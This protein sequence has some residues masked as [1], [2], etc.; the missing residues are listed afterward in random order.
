MKTKKTNEQKTFK[1]LVEMNESQKKEVSGGFLNPII[2]C[3]GLT[4]PLPP[5]DDPFYGPIDFPPF[6]W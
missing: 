2:I 5:Y 6:L 3:I 1:G 4:V